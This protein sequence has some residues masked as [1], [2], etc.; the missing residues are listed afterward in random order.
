M[1]L[2]EAGVVPEDLPAGDRNVMLL[3]D[4]WTHLIDSDPGIRRFRSRMDPASSMPAVSSLLN[5]WGLGSRRVVLD[6]FYFFTPIQER[7]IRI[8]ERSGYELVFLIPFR[9]EHP[10]ANEIWTSLY[11][12]RNG[13]EPPDRWQYIG[14]SSGNDFG[15]ILEG[16]DAALEN[17]GLVEY[18]NVMIIVNDIIHASCAEKL[19]APDVN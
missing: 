15:E 5:Q 7:I 3:K 17:V 8:I 12:P 14:S 9:K 11:S 19:Y 10:L 1:L 16:R 4:V 18:R 2:E 6:G 13:Y